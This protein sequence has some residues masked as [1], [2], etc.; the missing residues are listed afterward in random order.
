MTIECTE[1]VVHVDNIPV[2]VLAHYRASGYTSILPP[3]LTITG[4]DL[5][6]LGNV[7]YNYSI[8]RYEDPG[9]AGIKDQEA[10]A[11]KHGDKFCAWP[12]AHA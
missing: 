6:T 5:K 11:V 7:P 2:D 8:G 1:C 10:I 9:V 4:F 3:I 12:Q